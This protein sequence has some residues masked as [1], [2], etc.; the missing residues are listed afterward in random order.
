MVR[1]QRPKSVIRRMLETDKLLREARVIACDKDVME[2]RNRCDLQRYKDL[3]ARIEA[4]AS[5][6]VLQW[7]GKGTK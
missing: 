4:T 2:Y 7:D 1:K 5:V 3:E 6:R